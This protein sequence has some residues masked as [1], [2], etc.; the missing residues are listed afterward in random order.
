LGLG[1]GDI[2]RYGENDGNAGGLGQVAE[3]LFQCGHC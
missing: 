1:A 2:A 3:S